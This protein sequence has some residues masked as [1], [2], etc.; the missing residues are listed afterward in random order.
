MKVTNIEIGKNFETDY[1]LVYGTLRL[2]GGNWNW[3]LKDRS[4]LV[5]TSFLPGFLRTGG[6]SVHWTGNKEDKTVFD[7]FKALPEHRE[8]LNDRIDSLEGSSGNNPKN[9]WYIPTAVTIELEDGSQVVAKYYHMPG[10]DVKYGDDYYIDH[11]TP[12]TEK[13]IEFIKDFIQKAEKEGY[14]PCAKF[15]T[16][17]IKEHVLS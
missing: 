3:S 12:W 4:E 16:E 9:W 6:I 8:W 11:G 1:F 5:A 10:G 15:Y 14:T 17:Q 7:L 13:K 2:Y